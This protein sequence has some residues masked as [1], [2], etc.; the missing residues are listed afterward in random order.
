[1][2]TIY[3][4]PTGNDSTGDGSS[5]NPY[6]T[7]DKCYTVASGGDTIHFLAGTYTLVAQDFNKNL[8][9]EG[10]NNLTTFLDGTSTVTP[11]HFWWR[12]YNPC[13]IRQL[14]FQNLTGCGT[15]MF[16]NR[17]GGLLYMDR[18]IIHDCSFGPS[19]QYGYGVW[20]STSVVDGSISRMNACLLY[21][22]TSATTN[23]GTIF[24]AVGGNP[25]VMTIQ[26]YNT[27]IYLSASGG[28][29]LFALC[30]NV[31]NYVSGYSFINTII[32]NTG[33][34]MYFNGYTTSQTYQIINCDYSSST[35][36]GGAPS[37]P[38]INLTNTITSD[39][40]FID[41]VNAIFRL[42]PTSPCK[43][44]GIAI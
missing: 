10:D 44:T 12:F 43:G 25:N 15:V 2:A 32:Y 22:L 24:V 41:P 4:S 1:M 26:V 11:N 7:L 28:S 38:T 39:P 27:V 13:T 14:Q 29:R 30:E 34:T 5:G 21:N 8:T 33:S 9:I 42:K 36:T 23:S 20:G 18:C 3:L 40:Q 19:W 37:T 17:S 35:I 6:L 31:F 16:E